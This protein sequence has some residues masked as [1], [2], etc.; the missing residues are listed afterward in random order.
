MQIKG[1]TKIEGGLH[2]VIGRME[3]NPLQRK[4]TSSLSSRRLKM[5]LTIRKMT[6]MTTMERKKCRRVNAISSRS[7]LVLLNTLKKKTMA[8]TIIPLRTATRVHHS[9]NSS[10]VIERRSQVR[11]I[12]KNLRRKKMILSSLILAKNLTITTCDSRMKTGGQAMLS[13]V[14]PLEM[15]AKRIVLTRIFRGSTQSLK[16]SKIEG[17]EF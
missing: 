8:E 15:V 1:R 9:S 16:A 13:K 2:K 3:A 5:L 7:R 10:I 14:M 12:I 6:M 4:M 11:S 17:I